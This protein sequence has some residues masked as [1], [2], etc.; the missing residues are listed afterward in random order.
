MFQ[1]LFRDQLGYLLFPNP[2]FHSFLK[3]VEKLENSN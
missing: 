1:S 3:M 2:F